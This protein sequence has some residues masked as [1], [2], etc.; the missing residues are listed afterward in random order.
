MLYLGLLFGPIQQL[1]Q[2]FDGYQ[3]A[4]VGL[5]RIG[6]LLATPSS[7]ETRTPS[8][9]CR[10]TGRLRGE[11]DLDDVRFRYGGASEDALAD[12]RLH[13]PAGTTVALVGRTG[14][15]KST[16][17]KLLA[18]FYDPIR[19]GGAR[20]RRRP[21]PLRPAAV[22]G[23]LGVVP[24][25]AHLFTG[26]VASNI[27]FGRP[28]TPRAE[29]EAAAR[30]VGALETIADPAARDASARRRAGPG[31]LGGAASAVA[32]ARAQLVQPDLLLLDEATATLDPATERLVLDSSR[33]LA[34]RSTSVVVAHRLVTAAT[35]DV[36]V[37][38]DHGRSSKSA[39][40]RRCSTL[41][42]PT[43]GYGEPHRAEGE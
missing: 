22:P 27:A 35:A 40:M 30:A 1:S 20:R 31:S 37:V 34:R 13:I 38:V 9:P 2:V 24:Q 26:D 12:I 6:D 11:V 7:I 5:L 39:S 14:A 28:S 29:I 8:R 17:V 43:R 41:E 36:I 19:R 42:V 21:A 10:S 25:E 15:G 18:R 3:Q 33:A 16:I 4:R 32:L 23:R